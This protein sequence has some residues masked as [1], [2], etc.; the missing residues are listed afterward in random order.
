MD[1][2]E[3]RFDGDLLVSVCTGLGRA[4][5]ESTGRLYAKSTDCIGGPLLDCCCCHGQ[6]GC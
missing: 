3:A 5:D 4:V 6:M 1:E 2:A